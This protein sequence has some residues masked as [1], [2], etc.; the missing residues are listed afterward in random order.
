MTTRTK[1]RLGWIDLTVDDAEHV[2]DFYGA[3]VGWTPDDVDMGDYADFNMLD[4]AGTA[5]AGVCH[6]RGGNASMPTGWLPYFVVAD[7]DAA[8]AAALEGGGS[9]GDARTMG[10][11]ARWAIVRDPA[12]NAFAVWEEAD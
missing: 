11:S 9:V 2:R 5:V 10:G 4:D 1:G 3:V 7:L 6:R 8:L 12:G